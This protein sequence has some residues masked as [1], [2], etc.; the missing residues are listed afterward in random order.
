MGKALK[1]VGWFFGILFILFGLLLVFGGPI[2]VV[3]GLIVIFSGVL[4]CYGGH[5]SG[6]EEISYSNTNLNPNNPNNPNRSGR[7]G[8][9]SSFDPQGY[10][11]R[12]ERGFRIYDWTR[13]HNKH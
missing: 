4:M 10:F 8:G 13:R 6:R 5:R 1:V 9:S 7:A 3:I 12:H 2:G 11:R